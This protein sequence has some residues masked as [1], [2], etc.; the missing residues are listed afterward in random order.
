MNVQPA[1]NAAG[2]CSSKSLKAWVAILVKEVGTLQVPS[3]G[4]DMENLRCASCGDVLFWICVYLLICI[5]R[6][7]VF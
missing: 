1:G 2:H 3:M 5:F 6:C 7:S 4:F